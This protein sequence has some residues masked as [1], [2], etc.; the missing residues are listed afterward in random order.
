MLAPS[1]PGGGW[2]GK[3]SSCVQVAKPSL[4]LLPP[5]TCLELALSSSAQPSFRA[6]LRGICEPQSGL[7]NI[8]SK[9]QP[10]V[11]R[12]HPS[13]L[14]DQVLVSHPWVWCGRNSCLSGS[15]QWPCLGAE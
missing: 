10:W 14:L 6:G 2:Q 15:L 8:K 1:R 13:L 7:A 3:D 4:F 5:H 11:M 12:L 9:D